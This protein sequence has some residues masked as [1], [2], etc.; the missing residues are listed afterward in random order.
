MGRYHRSFSRIP[1]L[2]A[3]LPGDNENE[4]QFRS[5]IRDETRSEVRLGLG[6]RNVTLDHLALGRDGVIVAIDVQDPAGRRLADLGL[7]PKTRIRAVRR[8]PLGDPTVYELRGYRLCLRMGEAA[9]VE[10]NEVAERCEPTEPSSRT[11][12]PAEV[13]SSDRA[14]R[15]VDVT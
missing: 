2:L 5:E 15:D 6:A 4:F 3:T 8:A 9:R 12:N 1:H 14:V 10:I 7:V 11:A 13:D